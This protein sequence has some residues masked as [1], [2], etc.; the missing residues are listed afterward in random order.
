MSIK[1]IL[2]YLPSERIAAATLE[3]AIKIA[4]VRNAHIA[5][6]HLIP[7]LPLYGEFP[8]EVSQ[9]VVARLQQVGEDAEAAAKRAFEEA[10]KSSPITHEWRSFMASYGLGAELIA[11]EA[12][13]ADLIV[14]GKTSADVPDAW[15]D[16]AETAIMRSGR[17]V[18]IVPPGP[19]PK[20]IGNHA[21][22]AWNG[23][24]EAA[25]A[26]FDSIDL[27]R[28]AATVRAVT[29]VEKETQRPAA[30]SS[31]AALIATLAGT[32]S[33]QRWM[34]PMQAAARRVRPSLPSSPMKAA[35]CSLWADIATRASAK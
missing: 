25:R 33:A 2:V 21:V 24:R 27:I 28:D 5:G 1:T 4:S 8:A 6:L 20:Q 13:T 26:V 32:V 10:V 11:H 17:P 15:S 23:T 9:E 35:I 12:R 19:A 22:I 30:E 3:S 18:L 34:S 7:D 16:F 29:F 31:G 14:C